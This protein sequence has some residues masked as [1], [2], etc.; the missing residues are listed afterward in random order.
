[1]RRTLYH[2]GLQDPIGDLSDSV[3]APLELVTFDWGGGRGDSPPASED[4]W[5]AMPGG[6]FEALTFP[7]LLDGHCLTPPVIPTP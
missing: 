2:A 4:P 6:A 1:M 7:C 5:E 3:D